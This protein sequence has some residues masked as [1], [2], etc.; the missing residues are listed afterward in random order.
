[1]DAHGPCLDGTLCAG[2][3]AQG[4]LKGVGKR[5]GRFG[6]HG[7]GKSKKC[8]RSA[9]MPRSRS[10]RRRGVYLIVTQ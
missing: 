7:S 10:S 1:M 6:R 5:R 3:K 9:A 8:A 4:R 2:E